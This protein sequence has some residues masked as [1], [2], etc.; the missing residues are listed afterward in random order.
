[1]ERGERHTG[2]QK[3][4]K[5][6]VTN[7]RPI[8][9][10]PIF[11]KMFERLV[12]KNMYNYLKQNNLITKNQ[13]GFTPGDSGTNQLLSLVHDIHLAFD[14]NSCLEVRSVYLDMSKAFDKVW[15]EGL[16]HKLKQNGIEGNLL[17]LLSNY[18]SNRKQRVVLNGEMSDWAPIHSGVPQ[19]SVLGPLLFLIFINDLEAGIVS[20]IKF[21]ADDTSLYSVVKDP[22]ISA[23]ELN[24]DLLIISNWAKQWKMSFNPDPTKPAEE[25]LFSQKRQPQTHPPL[26]FNGVEVKRVSEHKHLGL[27]FDPKLNFAAHFKEKASNARKGKGSSST[28][29]HIFQ[30]IH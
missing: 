10:L 3:K 19:G 14:D 7:Y 30:Q 27:I 28:S 18:L 23:R 17:N 6:T 1:M 15:H 29:D 9:L 12:F 24:H 16:L 13:S 22:E 26:F 8:S 5:K 21:F 25:I 4:D 2:T 20:Q 11:A